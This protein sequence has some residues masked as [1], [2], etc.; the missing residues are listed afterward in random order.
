VLIQ[1][2]CPRLVRWMMAKEYFDVK[3]LRFFFNA[4]GVILVDR[5]GRD[6]S[7]TRAAMRALEDGYVLGIFPEGKIETT[8]ELLPFHQGIGLLALRSGAPV[9]P[10]Y[11]TG[12]Q[13]GREMV[14]AFLQPRKAAIS[15]A[16]PVNLADIQPTRNGVQEATERIR[17]SVLKLKAVDAGP[18]L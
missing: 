16:P 10:C 17:S 5:N 11:L 1:A 15:F 6:A 3:P 18:S 14:E 8:S 4:V 12:T 13:R 9:H 2:V 7:A